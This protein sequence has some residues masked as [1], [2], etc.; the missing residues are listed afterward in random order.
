[1][2]IHIILAIFIDSFLFPNL[3]CKS[4]NSLF[5]V[6]KVFNVSAAGSSYSIVRKKVCSEDSTLVHYKEGG[7]RVFIFCQFIRDK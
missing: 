5:L 7:S 4:G 6:Y 2:N 1:M 3:G